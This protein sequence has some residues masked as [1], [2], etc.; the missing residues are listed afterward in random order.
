MLERGKVIRDLSQKH[1][2]LLVFLF[3]FGLDLGK[4]VAEINIINSVSY[5][6]LTLP[7]ICSV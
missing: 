7:T 4:H 5:T 2:V 3:D 6:H 1:V